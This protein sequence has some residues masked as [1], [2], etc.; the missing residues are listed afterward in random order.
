[1]W[2]IQFRVLCSATG[3]GKPF[4]TFGT[5]PPACRLQCWSLEPYL[6]Q[7][8]LQEQSTRNMPGSIN[9]NAK[10]GAFIGSLVRTRPSTLFRSAMTILK[11]SG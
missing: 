11:R 3:V 6:K 7:W 10:K 5:E 9:G 4:F 2:I 1:M 8:L